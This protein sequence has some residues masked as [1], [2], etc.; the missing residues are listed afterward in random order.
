MGVK[1]KLDLKQINSFF[2]KYIFVDI[3]NT[4]E[5]ISDTV[6]ILKDINNKSYVLKL[7]ESNSFKKVEEEIKILNSIEHLKTPIV[8]DISRKYIKPLVLFSFKKGEIKKEASFQ[9]LKQVATFF[10][11]LHT[12]NLDFKTS[13]DFDLK[14]LINK[15]DNNEE[16]IK[17]YKHIKDIK[18]EKNSLI[19]ADLFFDN[20]LFYKDN[21]NTVLDFSNSCI[22]DYRFDLAII[23]L[24][25][26]YDKNSIN[27]NKANF[28]LQ[29]YDKKVTLKCIRSYLLYVCLYYALKRY[30]NLKEGIYK[31]VCYKEFL[32]KYDEIF[33][34]SF[35]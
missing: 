8:L 12:I 17:R 2:D 23:V 25:W 13:N 33:S 26:C 24:T 16:F 4:K 35:N 31:D 20:V 34:N 32:L 5:G 3:K 10:K 11:Q 9:N 14:P 19:H 7:Y 21:L 29:E 1:T 30:I 6:Y 28:F 22:S 27:E 15:L 18:V